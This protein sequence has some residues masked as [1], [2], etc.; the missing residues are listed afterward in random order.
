MKNLD[1][2]LNDLAALQAFRKKYP[3]WWYKIGVCDLSW[4]FD[5]APQGHSPEIKYIESGIWEDDAF[6]Y[7]SYISLEDAIYNIIYM[8]E[9]ATPPNN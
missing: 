3:T 4:D 8:I 6:M 5:C 7:D 2:T 1:L 9:M